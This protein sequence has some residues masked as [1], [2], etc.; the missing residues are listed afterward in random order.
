MKVAVVG[1]GYVGLP[2]VV[3]LGRKFETV[4]YDVD[5][6]RVSALQAG[7]DV[8][9]E[10]GFEELM[11]TEATFTTKISCLTSCDI[12]I[13]TVPTPIDEFRRPDLEPLKHA[14]AA[15]GGV[16]KR[17]SIIVFESTVYPGVTE[18]VCV[19]VLE[20]YS[21]MRLGK[22]FEVGYSP[23]RINPGDKQRGI[24]DI[25][26]LTSGSSPEAADVID[27][28]Y[29]AIIEAGTFPVSCIKVAEAAKVIENTQRD[30]NISLMNE[31][32]LIFNRIGLDT[33]EVLEAAC[34][35]WNF[36]PFKPG[37]VGGHCIGVDPYYLVH[38]A[39]SLG[40]SPDVIMSGRRVNNS[41]GKFVADTLIKLALARELL[42]SRSRA[43]I[44]G[45]AFK[46]NCPD[47]RNS[48]IYDVVEGLLSFD[49]EVDVWD[50]VVGNGVPSNFPNNPKASFLQ[51]PRT[52]E[53]YDIVALMVPHDQFLSMGLTELKSL[54]HGSA[55]FAD[56]KG[57]FPK[58]DSD[59]RL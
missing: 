51:K 14:S 48:K 58:G 44:L 55:V 1:L 54:G 23:E 41:M 38:K 17:G 29:G 39:E 42:P 45:Y 18:D 8:T 11:H 37:L 30:L 43:L 26:K 28:L 19:P 50:P 31:L 9:G 4:G 52:S 10:I 21:R 32:S 13:V 5:S 36:L 40:Y 27:A 57:V 46:E 59:F 3:E 49:M 47:A 2:L 22:D 33:N 24:T 12:I 20:E 34:T 25:V 56:V 6:L 35:K 7:N 15:I 16:M 53:K